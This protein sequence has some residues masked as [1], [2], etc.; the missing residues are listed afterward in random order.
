[1]DNS[2]STTSI[3]Q[4]GSSF[5][6]EPPLTRDE[7]C[8]ASAYLERTSGLGLWER[9]AAAIVSIRGY[10]PLPQVSVWVT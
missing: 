2:G 5:L 1:M 6:I 3:H 8:V 10:K 9:L 4:M 7:D